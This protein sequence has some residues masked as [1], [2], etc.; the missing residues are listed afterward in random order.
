MSKDEKRV[1]TLMEEGEFGGTLLLTDDQ[2]AVFAW[3]HSRGYEIYIKKM[4]DSQ[5]ESINASD[6]LN[7]IRV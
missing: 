5:P 1:Y 3:L 6:W 2:A 4:D 7:K